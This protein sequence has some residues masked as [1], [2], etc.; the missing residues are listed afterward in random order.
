MIRKWFERLTT[1][2]RDQVLAL[3]G[4]RARGATYLDNIVHLVE[5]VITETGFTITQERVP[6]KEG[7]GAALLPI[8]DAVNVEGAILSMD[9][10]YTTKKIAN[11]IISKKADYILALKMNQEKLYGEAEN[12]FDQA[13]MVE[14]SEAS[15]EVY[16]AGHRTLKDRF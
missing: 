9:A 14:P 16:T 15:V 2:L 6:S 7:E 1:D 11:L 4:K 13:C 3:D 12:Y 5:L 10:L 8:L